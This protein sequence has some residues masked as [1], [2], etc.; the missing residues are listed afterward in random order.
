MTTVEPLS[1]IEKL[2]LKLNL[3]IGGLGIN[4]IYFG[5]EG[6]GGILNHYNG[7]D[8]FDA[9]GVGQNC[10]SAQR[11]DAVIIFGHVNLN[12]LQLITKMIAENKERINVVI[13]I[14]GA[15]T[16]KNQEKSY[17]LCSDLEKHIDVDISYSRYPVDLEDL[18]EM[19]K[20]LQRSRING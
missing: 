1:Y 11:F 3:G 9:F 4:P 20:A 5:S 7:S 16:K 17:F 10:F 18:F 19:I 13:H 12:Q 8:H 2:L 14:R 6:S 15:L